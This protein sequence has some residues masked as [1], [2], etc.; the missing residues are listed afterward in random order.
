[1]PDKP[2]PLIDLRAFRRRE[3]RR[4]AFVIMA[5]LVVVG[6]LAIGVVYGWTTA[7]TGVICL[8]IGAGVFGL[9]WLILV[10]IERWLG[11]E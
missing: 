11:H 9:L 4:L 2:R 10:L 7:G 8:V 3:D 1:M 6:G 5:F